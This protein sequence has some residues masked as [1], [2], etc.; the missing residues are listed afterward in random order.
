M[1][2]WA[3]R[4]KE[5][6]NEEV[7]QERVKEAEDLNEYMGK[8]VQKLE[9]MKEDDPDL[10][11]DDEYLEQYRAQRIEALKAEAGKPQYGSLVEIQ[12]PEFEI[13]VNRAPKNVIVVISLYQNQYACL[14]LILLYSVPESL[15]LIQILEEVAR[16]HPHVKFIKM[17]ATKCIENYLD[18][19]VPGILF[20]QNGELLDKI[21][22]AS[23]VLGGK[24]MTMDTVE[25]VL[26]MK[27]VI[28]MEF[29]EDPRSKLQ[30]MKMQ[31]KNKSESKRHR[32][33]EAESDEDQEEDREYAS[34]QFFKYKHKY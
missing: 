15:L 14:S 1:G 22:P 18:I 9:E 34:N 25:F 32:G 30:Q 20:Y 27:K 11:E 3:P 16:K 17:V 4:E 28:P 13:E 31:I 19:D 33:N 6:S 5:P 8:T 29:E 24:Q 23:V 12:R 10:E 2:N 7:F 26:A 21:I